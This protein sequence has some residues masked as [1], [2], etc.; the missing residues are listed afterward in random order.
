MT[1]SLKKKKILLAKSSGGGSSILTRVQGTAKVTADNVST[2]AFTLSTPPSVGNAIIVSISAGGGSTP[3]FPAN[4]CV[5]N[6]GN[7]YVLAQADTSASKAQRT[8]IYY[9]SNITATGNPFTITVTSSSSLW[10]TGNA[11]EVSGRITVDKMA[12]GESSGATATPA[13]GPTTALTANNVLLIGIMT[14][15]FGKASLVVESLTPPWLQE[16]EELSA[17]HSVGEIDSRILTNALGTTPSGNW[18]MNSGDQWVAAIV[19][20]KAP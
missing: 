14:T 12:A 5:D 19:A 10:M 8:A 20:F 9:C 7:T 2:I 15:N 11:I 13:S 3:A 17:S 1:T 18:V 6:R 16:V 4:G